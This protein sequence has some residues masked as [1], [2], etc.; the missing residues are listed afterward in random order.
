MS[1]EEENL[2]AGDKKQVWEAPELLVIDVAKVTEGG[3]LP[4]DESTTSFS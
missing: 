1:N 2:A 3:F 4:G